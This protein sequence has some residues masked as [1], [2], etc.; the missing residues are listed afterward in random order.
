MTAIH[1]DNLFEFASRLKDKTVIITGGGNGIGKELAVKLATYGAKI[2]IADLN[3]PA[4]QQVVADISASKG[5]AT[6]K[7]CDVT[8]WDSLVSVFEHAV[9]KFGS[10]DVVV[11][12][13]GVTEI[14]RFS[15]VAYDSKGL[16]RPPNLKTLEINLIGVLYTAHLARIYLSR[17]QKPNSTDLKALILL[18]SMASW[19]AIPLGT[20]YSAA[21]HGVLGVMRSLTP[22]FQM[23]GIRIGCI[24]PWFAD[25]QLVPLEM[26][27]FL[28]GLPMVPVT[29]VAGA[30]A[31]AATSTAPTDQGCTWLLPDDG[32][33]IRLEQEQFK[34]GVYGLVDK[35]VSATFK[36]LGGVRYFVLWAKEIARLLKLKRLVLFAGGL[37]LARFGWLNR[38]Y[39][40]ATFNRY[41]R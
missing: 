38:D 24:H 21:K 13:A 3:E 29:R 14:G 18:G 30:I 26:K 1:D 32:P 2:V 20:M 27:L 28:A 4:S 10:V 36:A 31:Y 23:M 39:V 41:N 5:Q 15:V 17:D 6:F 9:Q 7:K 22:E 40:Q 16:P 37:A 33:V 19:Q 12:N 11:A 34:L 35:R 25:T 8:N